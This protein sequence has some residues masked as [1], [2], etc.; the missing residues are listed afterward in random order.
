VYECMYV[1]C[2]SILVEI[3][4]IIVVVVISSI[5][6][7]EVIDEDHGGYDSKCWTVTDKVGA[8]HIDIHQVPSSSEDR[9]KWQILMTVALSKAK[10]VFF[11]YMPDP[12]SFNNICMPSFAEML[13]NNKL[14][15][16]LILF[17]YI[18][19]FR[20]SHNKEM[21]FLSEGLLHNRSITRIDLSCCRIGD[22]GAKELCS[23]L[24]VNHSITHVDLS[25]NRIVF[26]PEDFA[27]LT[28]IKTLNLDGNYDLR[29]PPQ[30]VVDDYA[31]LFDF[32][33]D[34]RCFRMKFHFLMGFHERVGKQSSIQSYLGGSTIFEPALLSCIF[35]MVP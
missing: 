11:L 14:I 1:S 28:H 4:L 17:T 7:A 20:Q 35:E 2:V 33:A 23:V 24:E 5:P 34:F 13:K 15:T 18:L 3:I 31:K 25:F 9:R 12:S 26:I 32:F 21:Q 8:F 29:F 10:I 19:S 27:F 6:Y 22:A 30:K 16:T